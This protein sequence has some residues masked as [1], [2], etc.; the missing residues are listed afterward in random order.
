MSAPPS[1][2]RGQRSIVDRQTAAKAGAV[3]PALFLLRPQNCGA[4]AAHA[5]AET[6]RVEDDPKLSRFYSGFYLQGDRSTTYAE[7]ATDTKLAR[8]RRRTR[9]RWFEHINSNSSQP[10]PVMDSASE[11]IGDFAGQIAC[12]RFRRSLSGKERRSAP[13]AAARAPAMPYVRAIL[14]KIWILCRK[15]L[16]LGNIK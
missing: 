13:P 3:P 14:A 11:T 2:R 15:I 5:L 8:L 12:S 6:G 10:R 16:I 4:A 9:A 1:S 7:R